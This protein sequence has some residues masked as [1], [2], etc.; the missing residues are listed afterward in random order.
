MPKAGRSKKTVEQTIVCR[1]C[2]QTVTFTSKRHGR[3]FCS[4]A[5]GENWR[6]EE[7]RKRNPS[8][9]LSASTTGA[10]S[11]LF[12]AVDLLQRG[13]D[14]F[15]AVSPS[16]I[17]DLAIVKDQKL[18]R[19]EVKTGYSTASGKLQYSAGTGI[20]RSKFDILAVVRKGEVI[21]DPPEF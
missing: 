11:E 19:V 10:I 16:S 12:V 13:Y 2:W 5:C 3:L 9:G 18:L 21:Y 7:W 14:V 17:C 15:R 8:L 6:K 1:M 4:K 20:D